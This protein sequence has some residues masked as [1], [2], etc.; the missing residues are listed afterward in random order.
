MTRCH[1]RSATDLIILENEVGL[2]AA[3]VGGSAAALAGSAAA[4]AVGA[5]GAVAGPGVAAGA[6]TGLTARRWRPCEPRYSPRW[7]T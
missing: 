5:V 3:A 4:A 7:R 1:G 6:V 2:V